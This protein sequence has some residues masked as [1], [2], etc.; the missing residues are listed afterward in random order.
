MPLIV[1]P[2]RGALR[3]RRCATIVASLMVLLAM[4]MAIFGASLAGDAEIQGYV[5]HDWDGDSIR[6]DGEPILGNVLIVLATPE[7]VVVRSARTDQAGLY[8]LTGLSA[9]SYALF[10]TDP[11]GYGSTTPNLKAIKLEDGEKE[12]IDFGDILSLIGC[13]RRVDGYVWHDVDGDG[14]RDADEDPIPNVPV[15]VI[16]LK[17]DIAGITLSDERGSYA[18]KSLPPERYQVLLE[19]P[20]TYPLSPTPLHWGIDLRG[21]QPGIIDFGLRTRAEM[22][23]SEQLPQPVAWATSLQITTAPPGILTQKSLFAAGG[24][25]EGTSSVSGTI[26]RLDPESGSSSSGRE[27]VEGIRVSLRDESGAAIGEQFSDATGA[28]RFEGLLWQHYY[29]THEPVGDC[30][31]VYSRFWGVVATDASEILIDLEN[32]AHPQAELQLV[33]L[34]FAVAAQAR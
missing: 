32:Q 10:E 21:C 22:T 15:R 1:R 34:P 30:E 7:G 29:L 27:A 17:G 3:V 28:Y 25:R 11:L 31:P 23:M 26:W 12:E 5:W 14:E 18:L 9:G 2:R 13:F 20:A 19:P 6:E 16:D 24:K 8:Q 33:F 4:P